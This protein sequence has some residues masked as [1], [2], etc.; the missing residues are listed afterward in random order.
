MTRAG[1]KADYKRGAFCRCYPTAPCSHGR[2]NSQGIWG[3]AP[4]VRM[5]HGAGDHAL[6]PRGPPFC[7]VFLTP[8]PLLALV[9]CPLH[10]WR[11]RFAPSEDHL[12]AL[13]RCPRRLLTLAICLSAPLHARLLADASFYPSFTQA[14]KQSCYDQRKQPRVRLQI[15]MRDGSLLPVFSL[16]LRCSFACCAGICR[17]CSISLSQASTREKISQHGPNPACEDAPRPMA[18]AASSC[19]AWADRYATPNTQGNDHRL[20]S[21]WMVASPCASCCNKAWPVCR[22]NT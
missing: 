10:A 17:S 19:H 6:P 8:S 4:C 3:M 12:L 20:R 18:T 15:R 9:C 5:P 14:C 13:I 22:A 11:L 1:R 16:F 21:Q 7:P 2:A